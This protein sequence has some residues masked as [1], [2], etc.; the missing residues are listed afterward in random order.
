MT[1][2]N[3]TRWIG[4]L[5]LGACLAL[6]PAMV[7][8]ESHRPPSAQV[9]TPGGGGAKAETAAPVEGASPLGYA[10]REAQ[11]PE[12]A[13]FEGGHGGGVYIGG[14]AVAVVLVILLIVVL[15]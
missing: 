5:G 2:R 1:K 15:L 10:E 11:S 14:S 8:A 4:S 7:R 6:A 12:A 9:A 13:D 3:V